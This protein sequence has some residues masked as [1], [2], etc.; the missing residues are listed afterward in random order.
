[1]TQ[2]QISHSIDG[3]FSPLK[4]QSSSFDDDNKYKD[5]P[6]FRTRYRGQLQISGRKA[7]D[8]LTLPKPQGHLCPS[9]GTSF[10]LA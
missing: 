5:M 8:A 7:V 9:K 1:M 6:A 2:D 3:W 4:N 10:A